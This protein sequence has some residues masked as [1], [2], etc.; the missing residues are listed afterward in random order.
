M[1]FRMS[2]IVNLVNKFKRFYDLKEYTISLI[3]ELVYIDDIE[4]NYLQNELDYSNFNQ[5]KFN[6]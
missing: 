1:L 4:S 5:E 6:C 2:K 3:K